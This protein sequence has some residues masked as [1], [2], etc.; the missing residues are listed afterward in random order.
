MRQLTLS[1]I[2]LLCE[3]LTVS[4]E[5]INMKTWKRVLFPSCKFNYHQ[6]STHF[7]VSPPRAIDP[8]LTR[9]RIVPRNFAGAGSTCF[10]PHAN[11]LG[12]A[13]QVIS[14]HELRLTPSSVF[15]ALRPPHKTVYCRISWA[16]GDNSLLSLRTT[17][18]SPPACSII[19]TESDI[20]R[21][22]LWMRR[23]NL[24]NLF[25]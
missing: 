13:L 25:L 18:F 11:I 16:S 3:C 6:D 5:T 8:L 23:R 19:Q 12:K 21:Q 22:Q 24:H 20:R 14:T 17:G 9:R 10:K 7:W 2:C 1:C 15:H 4:L